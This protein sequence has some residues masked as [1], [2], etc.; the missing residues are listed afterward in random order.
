MRIDLTKGIT[1][2]SQYKAWKFPGGEIHVQLKDIIEPHYETPKFF[3]ISTRLNTS[4]DIMFLLIFTDMLKKDYRDAKIN[5]FLPYMP[6]QQ[7]DKNFGR[8]E[9][10]S[11]KT[12]CNLINSMNYNTVTLFDPHSDVS[13]ALLNNCE[14]QDNS[15]FIRTVIN[16][17]YWSEYYRIM[18][19]ASIN[20][21]KKEVGYSIDSF[22]NDIII[23]SP[24]A[25]AYK[26]IFK[27]CEKIGFTGQIETCSKSRNHKTGE[28]TLK[29]PEFDSNKL[30]L[31]VDDIALGSRT[32]FN[33]RKGLK[34]ENVYLAVSHGIFNDNVGR[35]ETEFTK[36]FTTNSRRNEYITNNLEIINI[37]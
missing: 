3:D 11:L 23:V 35:L 10:F 32:F 37:F 36:V 14:V 24:D 8:N 9:C 18:S 5:L 7:A 16:N 29:I 12:M 33:I 31:I 27:L 1:E 30:V 2:T 21:T 6:Y 15:E 28:L 22:Y 4:D 34:N 26:K 17:I 13:P 19:S 25:S 20:D